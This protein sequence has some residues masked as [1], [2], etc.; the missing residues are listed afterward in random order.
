MFLFKKIIAPLLFP[1]PLC[2]L[3][4]AI[5]ILLLWFSR[6]QRLGKILTTVAFA[7]LL[8]LSYGPLPNALL[9][10]I[11]GQYAPLALTVQ[12]D[13]NVP[14]SLSG[15]KWIVVLGGGHSSDAK[16]PAVSNLYPGT[17]FRLIEAV[18]LHRRLP[19]TKL[20]LSGSG[21]WRS[22]SEAEAMARVA[23][24]LGVER[25]SI[26]LEEKSNDTEDQ[27]RL[28]KPIIGDEPA[29]LVTSAAHMP[30]AM[31]LFKRAGM[32]PLPAP[33]DYKAVD[34][35]PMPRDYYPSPANL[36]KSEWAVYEG[37][38]SLWAKLRGKG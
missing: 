23:E 33:T 14:V 22:D 20:L 32:N 18:K 2:L 37:L 9:R 3:L 21:L 4:M 5:G 15:V 12:P 30:R 26:V 13:A 19:D 31:A 27:A 38:G 8:L 17:L 25:Q 7:L 11:E 34:A 36:Q 6:R 35:E 1:L 10:R 29:I 24:A 16:I 28:I